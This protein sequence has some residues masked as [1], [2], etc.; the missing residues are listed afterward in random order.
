MENAI[1][2]LMRGLEASS[3]PN[4]FV[5]SGYDTTAQRAEA[6]HRIA[7]SLT[8]IVGLVRMHATSVSKQA[9]SMSSKEVSMLLVEVA[10]RIQTVARLHRLLSHGE[11]RTEVDLGEYLREICASLM[12]SFSSAGNVSLSLN[13]APGCLVR[14]DHVVSLGLIVSEMITNSFKHAHPSGVPGRMSVGCHHTP[15]GMLCVDVADDGVGLPD[16][17][18]PQADGGL[19]F[20]LVRSLGQQLGAKV[21]FEHDC[22]GLRFR[23]LMP[24]LPLH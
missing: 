4:V 21:E 14:S 9:K 3:T 2:G 24:A 13:S 7:N 15:E 6:D 1:V 16:G 19:G 17:F 22:L 12:S 20:R 10:A 18:D 5:P 11:Q 8:L 23:L